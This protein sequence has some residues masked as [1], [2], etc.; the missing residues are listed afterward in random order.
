MAAMAS[1]TSR[2][3]RTVLDLVHAM[4]ADERASTPCST[5]IPGWP[6][7]GPGRSAWAG[8]SRCPSWPS[9]SRCAGCRSGSTTTCPG[10]PGP[11]ALRVLGGPPV[12]HHPGVQPVA[13]GLHRAGPGDRG[14]G[15]ATL[16]AGDGPAGPADLADLRDPP[17][18]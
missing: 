6:R 14:A 9:R 4:H 12:R 16:G 13:A 8:P 18:W 10:H 2:D 1:L 3:L 11:A 17:A 15:H 5:S 7:T